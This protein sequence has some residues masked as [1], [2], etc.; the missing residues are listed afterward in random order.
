MSKFCQTKDRKHES[1]LLKWFGSTHLCVFKFKLL[2]GLE[3]VI[4]DGVL[5]DE[6]MCELRK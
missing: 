4:I 3:N 2:N 6:M 5:V 1:K